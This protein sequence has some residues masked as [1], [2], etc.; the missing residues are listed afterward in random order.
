MDS[1]DYQFM[2]LSNNSLHWH[3]KAG[4][5]FVSANVLWDAMSNGSAVQCW[6]TYKMLMGLSFELLFKSIAIQRK[7]TFSATHQLVEIANSANL[8]LTIDEKEILRVLTEYILWDGKYP[9]PHKKTHLENH[10]KH[11]N[12]V[13]YD[14]EKR[15]ILTIQRQ[16]NKLDFDE[17]AIIW[18]KYSDLYMIEYTKR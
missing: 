10:W 12:K 5:L 9:V 4:D 11:E 14:K 13:A 8:K 3:N 15:G 2:N 17:L 6:S 16:N 18:R 1:Y 7:L